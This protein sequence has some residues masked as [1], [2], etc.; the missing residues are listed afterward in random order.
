MKFSNEVSATVYLI[1]CSAVSSLTI[2]IGSSITSSL[3]TS[4]GSSLLFTSNVVEVVVIPLDISSMT[5]GSNSVVSKLGIN[6]EYASA[7]IAKITANN[8]M[9]LFWFSI[10]NQ[11]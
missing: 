9:Y 2:L 11:I 7:P 3:F 5:S 10:Y 1:N 4:W 6:N 8:I